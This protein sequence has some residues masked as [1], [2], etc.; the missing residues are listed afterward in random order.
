MLILLRFGLLFLPSL[1]MACLRVLSG[2]YSSSPKFSFDSV[3]ES[4]VGAGAG[5]PKRRLPDGSTVTW[6]KNQTTY[7]FY[8]VSGHFT[9]CPSPPSRSPS[10]LSHFYLLA[11]TPFDYYQM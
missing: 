5:A 8:A 9:T 1:C 3:I 4:G 11:L 2:A 7:L 6:Y 10:P